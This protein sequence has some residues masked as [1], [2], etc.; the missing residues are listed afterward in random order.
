[1]NKITTAL[2]KIFQEHRIVFWYNTDDSLSFVFNEISIDGVEKIF[3]D[4]DEFG[5][6]YRVIRQEPGKKYLLYFDKQKPEDSENWLLDLNLGGCEFYTDQS[7]LI[8]QDLKLQQEFKP[9]VQEHIQF[10]RLAKRTEKLAELLTPKDLERKIRIKMLS[11]IGSSEPNIHN[12]IFSLLSDLAKDKH[13]KY[14]LISECKL[15]KFFWEEVERLFNYKSSNPSILDFSLELFKANFDHYLEKTA[16]LSK[17]AIVLLSRWQD[18][19][20]YQKDFETLSDRFEGELQIETKIESLD[21]KKLLKNNMFSLIEK[22]ILSSIRLGI[23]EETIKYEDIKEVIRSREDGYWYKDYSS[24]YRALEYA[25]DMFFMIDRLDLTFGTLTEGFNKYAEY[26]Y[27]VDYAYRKFLL[28]YSATN[29]SPLLAELAAKVEKYYSNKYL[30][31]LNDKWQNLIDASLGWII[32]NVKYQEEFFDTFINPFLIK[33]QK[34]FVIISDA[35]RYEIGQELLS[36]IL[37]ENRFFSEI[38]AMYTTLPSYTKL[39]MAAMLPHSKL[40]YR[41]DKDEVLCDDLSSQG[42]ISRAKILQKRNEDSEAIQADEFLAMNS[43]AEGRDFVKANSLIYIYSNSI[44][45]IGD[46]V[47]SEA[48]VIKAVEDEIE[49]IIRLL[50]HIVNCNGVNVIITSDHGFIYQNQKL[51]ESDFSEIDKYGEIIKDNRRFIIGKNLKEDPAVKKYTSAQL[52]IECENEFLI[53]KSI[54]RLRVRRSGSRYVH[55]GASLQEIVI[56]VIKFNKKRSGEIEFVDVDVIRSFS[57]ITSNQVA[58]SFYQTDIVQE[59]VQARELRAGF[60]SKDN[61]PLSDQ[62]TIIFNSTYDEATMR[63]KKYKFTLVASANKYNNQ[64]VFLRL[65]ERIANT[66][67]FRLYKEFPYKM[68]I[69]FTKDFD[70]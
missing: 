52:G 46:D 16:S 56:P 11:V 4:N 51:D 34:I 10:F 7:S 47:D 33:E 67:Q 38:D 59:K 60:Y 12:I 13:D 70:D 42:T 55:G 37:K 58:I 18:S 50:K 23:L 39:G 15:D 29:S 63:E 19:A 48:K 26:Y 6:K 8:L 31:P 25:L 40:S 2:E 35:L 1:M 43:R 21:Y 61:K 44:D 14:D 57:K 49:N 32:E 62:A 64:D 24:Y 27:K 17:E 65:E 30:L 68:F 22:K 45:K 53:T 41:T 9:L 36:R 5:V 66:N 69:S 3:V 54:N 20:R 28:E